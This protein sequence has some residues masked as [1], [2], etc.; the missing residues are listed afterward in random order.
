MG[1]QSPLAL[2]ECECC[3]ELHQTFQGTWGPEERLESVWEKTEEE[4]LQIMI[5]IDPVPRL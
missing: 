2:R 3:F 4:A 1:L 5:A